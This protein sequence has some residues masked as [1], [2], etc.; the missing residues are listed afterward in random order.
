MKQLNAKEQK[1]ELKAP[2]RMDM[3]GDGELEILAYHEDGYWEN[4]S[5]PSGSSSKFSYR[6]K[7]FLNPESSFALSV[8]QKN[9]LVSLGTSGFRSSHLLVISGF[10][11]KLI[12][13]ILPIFR[14]SNLVELIGA[15]STTMDGMI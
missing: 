8:K 12:H 11:S 13:A 6:D 3:D 14:I 10:P 4:L 15:T 2:V 7:Y 5:D 1:G 9:N